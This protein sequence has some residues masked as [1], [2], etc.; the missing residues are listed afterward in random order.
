M[1]KKKRGEEGDRKV[2][3][4]TRRHGSRPESQILTTDKTATAIN[5]D[6]DM[7]REKQIR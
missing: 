3:S 7:D 4:L 6:G 1:E 5:R 2:A